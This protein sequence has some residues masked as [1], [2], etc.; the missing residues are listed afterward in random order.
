MKACAK[1]HKGLPLNAQITSASAAAISDSC[2]H[3]TKKK[4]SLCYQ[5]KLNKKNQS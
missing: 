4:H 5:E 3:M 1:V 2:M